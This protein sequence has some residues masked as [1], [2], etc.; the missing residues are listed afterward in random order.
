MRYLKVL[1]LVLLFFLSMLFVVQNHDALMQELS[2][3]L[4]AFGV[5]IQ[6]PATP[7]Y[8]T[9]LSSFLVGAV[10]CTLYFF[11]ERMRLSA[12]VRTLKKQ[13]AELEAQVT[14]NRPLSTPAEE[15]P[16]APDADSAA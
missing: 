8:I 7:Y 1:G 6:M 11:L 16:I 3:S 9:I 14:A 12:Q 10:L 15:S 5:H 4:S 2:L 13:V